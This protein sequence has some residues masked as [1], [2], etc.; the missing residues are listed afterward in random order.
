VNVENAETPGKSERK[1]NFSKFS[2]NIQTLA[3][4]FLNYIKKIFNILKIANS[5][6]PKEGRSAPIF[7]NIVICCPFTRFL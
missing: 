6:S 2:A 7:S 1:S 4:Y 3:G 5:F